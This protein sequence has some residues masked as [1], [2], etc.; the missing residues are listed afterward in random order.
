MATPERRHHHHGG[1]ADSGG[2]QQ[3]AAPHPAA[4]GGGRSDGAGEWVGEFRSEVR[5]GW[6]G[7]MWVHGDRPVLLDQREAAE[8]VQPVAA[9]EVHVLQAQRRDDVVAQRMR[10]DGSGSR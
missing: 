7:R 8:G 1:G 2:G 10:R 5:N 4:G 3:H 6:P 9:A